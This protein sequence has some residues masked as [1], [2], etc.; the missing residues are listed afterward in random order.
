MFKNLENAKNLRW[1]AMD[2]KVDGIMRHP[3]DTPSW[4]LIDH[5]WPTFGSEPRNLRLDP[6]QPGYDINTYLAPLIDDLKILWEEGVRCFDV[7]KE[8]YFTLR[9]EPYEVGD[10]YYVSVKK[11]WIRTWDDRRSA[12]Y[13]VKESAG[14]GER[15]VWVRWT[16]RLGPV[17]ESAGWAGR[18]SAKA[19]LYGRQR[20]HDS[21]Q[22]RRIMAGRFRF[23]R[24]RR[25]GRG[26]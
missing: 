1:H 12:R 16:N 26:K 3:A 4:R 13:E 17:G 6:K 2:R 24:G 8:E 18:A 9:A 25:C 11:K 15:I 19:G 23:G 22:L 7:H 10:G 21:R 14:F 20:K 5:M